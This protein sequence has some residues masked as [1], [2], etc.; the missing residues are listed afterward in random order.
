[1]QGKRPRTGGVVFGQWWLAGGWL[2]EQTLP[3][4]TEVR[5]VPGKSMEHWSLPLPVA[6]VHDPWALAAGKSVGKNT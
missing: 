5:K 2:P 3:K 6:E 1:M 4:E